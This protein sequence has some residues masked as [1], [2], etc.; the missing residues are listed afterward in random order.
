[1]DDVSKVFALIVPN[2][3]VFL[4]LLDVVVVVV[5]LV[6]GDIVVRLVVVFLVLLDDDFTLVGAGFFVVLIRGSVLSGFLVSSFKTSVS[7]RQSLKFKT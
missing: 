5:V 2:V 1:M 4:V 3:V 7:E 6:V